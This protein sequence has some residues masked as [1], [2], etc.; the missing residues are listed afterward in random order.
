VNNLLEAS[1]TES[2]DEYLA[3]AAPSNPGPN[4]LT[5][6]LLAFAV[7]AASIG[8]YVY[9]GQKPPVAVGEIIRLTAIPIHSET[10]G[11]VEAGMQGQPEVFDEVLVMAQVK[12]H[13]QSKL[14]LFLHDMYATLSLPD[15]LERRSLAVNKTDFDRAF[16]AYPQLLPLKGEPLVRDI[17]IEPGQTVE[18]LMLFPYPISG[19]QYN[20][21][22]ALDLNVIFLHQKTLTMPAPK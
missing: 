15:E 6:V 13:N 22:T 4:A 8:A 17:T 18:G 20:K 21:K 9:F 14:P 7:V 3:Q 1:S 2:N 5:V 11:P 12:L 10:P 19:D 16:I